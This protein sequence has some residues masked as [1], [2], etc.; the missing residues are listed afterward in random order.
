METTNNTHPGKFVIA[1]YLVFTV[2]A[3]SSI[4]IIVNPVR[5]DIAPFLMNFWRFLVGTI[6]L[7]PVLLWTSRARIRQLQ[8]EDVRDLAV[9]G[10]LNILLSMGAHALCIKY[11]RA[12]TAAV[13]ISANPLATNFFAWLILK[14]RMTMRRVFALLLGLSGII[15][16]TY[17]ADATVD[18]PF[19]VAAGVFAMAGFGLYTVLSKRLVHRHG[20]LMVMV[21]SCLPALAIY[22]PLL[23]FA[24]VGLWPPAHTWPNILGAGILGTGLGYLAFMKALTFLSAGRCSY[25]FFF[26]PPVAMFLAWLLLGEQISVSAITG[27]VLIMA[28]I[29]TE[30]KR[31]GQTQQSA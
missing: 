19:G 22:V 16:L 4:E 21:L 26:K 31:A 9:L 5:N 24:G 2:I 23:H 27:T 29:L 15:V 17:K 3:F 10:C 20:G 6:I 14:E 7:L 11:A 28:G 25:L 18:Q 8:R 13:L 1:F 12:S 30:I